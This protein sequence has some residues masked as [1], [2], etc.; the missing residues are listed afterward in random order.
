MNIENLVIP[1]HIGIIMDGNRRW[2]K[3]RGLASKAGHKA[4]A[5]TLKKICYYA[6]KIG[7]KYLS[8]FAFST[9][10]FKRDAAE[11]K[12]LMDLFLAYFKSNFGRKDNFRIVFSGRRDP[13]SDEVWNAMQDIVEST[14]NNTGLTLNI[15][16]NYGG[17]GELV[18]VIRDTCEKYK[19][20]VISLEDITE[21]YISDN[22]Y[23]P[24][25]DLDFV[26]R[27]S[28]EQRISNFMLYQAS[29]AEFYFTKVYFPDFLE[30]QFEEALVEYNR[31]TRKFGGNL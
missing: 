19:N 21:K 27:T 12:Y 9:E 11:V 13:L 29:Y 16:L 22:L 31:R 6:N 4:G 8:V 10:N 5:E 23:Q 3:E 28:G 14:K 26:I 2:A 24:L 15:C 1:S 20:N 17:R 7:L 30:R 18:D 25:P